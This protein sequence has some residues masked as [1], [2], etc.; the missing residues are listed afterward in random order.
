MKLG[1]NLFGLPIIGDGSGS[2][3]MYIQCPTTFNSNP[4]KQ[5]SH[6]LDVLHDWQF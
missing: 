3:V 6:I 5:I 1:F 4:G 2:G